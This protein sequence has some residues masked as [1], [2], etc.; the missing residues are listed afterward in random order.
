MKAKEKL[1]LIYNKTLK[2]LLNE[3]PEL[4]IQE[5]K[6]IDKSIK[7]GLSKGPSCNEI[8]KNNLDEVVKFHNE[9]FES[10]CTRLA[11]SYQEN[12]WRNLFNDGVFCF[13]AYFITIFSFAFCIY[14]KEEKCLYLSCSI[15]SLILFFVGFII[16]RHHLFRTFIG[17]LNR[18]TP[19]TTIATCVAFNLYKAYGDK[20]CHSLLILLASLA[21]TVILTIVEIKK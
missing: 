20:A 16:I 18:V 1:S 15:V 17:A 4:G 8:I 7:K 14:I 2:A 5:A 10:K 21:S 3:F 6:R 9:D 11:A 12:D 13:I 19:I